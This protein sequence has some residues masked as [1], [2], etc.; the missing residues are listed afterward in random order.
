MRNDFDITSRP[1]CFAPPPPEPGF[2]AQR[3]L[4]P[5][6]AIGSPAPGIMGSSSIFCKW[7]MA[8]AR[9][10]LHPLQRAADPSLNTSSSAPWVQVAVRESGLMPAARRAP[11]ALR[12][13]TNSIMIFRPSEKAALSFSK[14]ESTPCLRL[15]ST[16][17]MSTGF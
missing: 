14:P 11:E 1:L 6:L 7:E 17:G 4:V 10:S 9:R 12:E 2:L 8:P 5:R 15:A 3:L 13:S 16:P